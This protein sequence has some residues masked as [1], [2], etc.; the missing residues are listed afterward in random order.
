[1]CEQAMLYDFF[2]IIVGQL[3]FLFFSPCFGRGLHIRFQCRPLLMECRVYA[4][5][6]RWPF[7]RASCVKLHCSQWDTDTWSKHHLSDNDLCIQVIED[8]S[9]A[10]V[11]SPVDCRLL[12]KGGLVPSIQNKYVMQVMVWKKTLFRPL[13]LKQKIDGELAR[14]GFTCCEC[15]PAL[16]WKFT[17][18]KWK[19]TE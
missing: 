7:Y 11:C 9:R 2:L 3:L 10:V 17:G 4:A 13:A 8:P 5:R 16:Q 14:Y 15:R 1:M 12:L 6:A 19:V 18:W